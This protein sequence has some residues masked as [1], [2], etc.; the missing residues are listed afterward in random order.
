LLG[1]SSRALFKL[2]VV[3]EDSFSLE[4][5]FVYPNPVRMERSVRFYYHSSQRAVLQSRGKDLEYVDNVAVT[6]KV[7]TLSGKLVRV[8]ANAQNGL[9]WDLRDQVGNKLGP[10]VYLVQATGRYSDA[11]NVVVESKSPIKK[12]VIHPPR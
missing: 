4:Q 7:Y 11:D 1:N 2:Q 5:F 12:L 9:S 6:L 8:F 10:N 3:D